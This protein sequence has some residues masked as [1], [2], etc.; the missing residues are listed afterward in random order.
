M[1]DDRMRP[2]AENLARAINH[3]TNESPQVEAVIR[4]FRKA[5][6]EVFVGLE[7]AI[8]LIPVGPEVIAELDENF[9]RS[10]RIDPN[11]T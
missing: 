7:I 10:L 9:L 8:G 5:G 4:E 2:Y 6:F 3:A 1:M 11:N